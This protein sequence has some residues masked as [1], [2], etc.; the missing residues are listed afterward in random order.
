MR[1][2]LTKNEAT[3]RRFDKMSNEKIIEVKQNMAGRFESRKV[4]DLIA[5]EIES[6]QKLAK[7]QSTPGKVRSQSKFDS[8]RNN[9]K[10][11]Q[12]IQHYNQ[13]GNRSVS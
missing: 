3:E 5:K 10:L 2:E 9:R 11:V 7:K 13:E 1:R 12:T 8:S 6:Y 4:K